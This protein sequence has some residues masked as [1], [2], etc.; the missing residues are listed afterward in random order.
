MEWH[1]HSVILN[2]SS[3]G[4]KVIGR[5]LAG[6]FSSDTADGGQGPRDAAA[7][8]WLQRGGR[9]PAPAARPTHSGW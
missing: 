7:L 5:W 3:D 6:P 2:C 4:K 9:L 8:P 1:T